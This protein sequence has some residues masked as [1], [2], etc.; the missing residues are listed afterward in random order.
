[1]AAKFG[2]EAVRRF[3]LFGQKMQ[4]WLFLWLLGRKHELKKKGWGEKKVRVRGSTEGGSYL[5]S[6]NFGFFLLPKVGVCI[7]VT[8]AI[9]GWRG[10]VETTAGLPATVLTP[11]SRG[12]P[13][14]WEK[15]LRCHR[16]PC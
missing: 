1:M 5:L 10:T 9:S 16:S 3:S 13:C 8:R 4:I 15:L 11:R 14:F 6:S 7:L 12:V 2:R